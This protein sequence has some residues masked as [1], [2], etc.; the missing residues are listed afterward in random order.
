MEDKREMFT[1]SG[2]VE[3]AVIS[4]LF[5]NMRGKKKKSQLGKKMEA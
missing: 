4:H 3:Q 1:Y 2:W 5:W